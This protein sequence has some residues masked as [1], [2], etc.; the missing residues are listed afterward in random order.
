MIRDPYN[1][2]YAT[3]RTVAMQAA[4]VERVLLA[5]ENQAR[6]FKA[7]GWPEVV[8]AAHQAYS[9][10]LRKE[11]GQLMDRLLET[12]EGTELAAWIERTRGLGPAILFVVGMLPP[13]NEFANPSKVWKY[14]GLHVSDGRAPRRQAGVMAGFSARLRSYAIYRVAEPIVKVGGPYRAIYHERKARTMD[15][16]PDMLELSGGCE[17][18]DRARDRS[19][20]SREAKSLT[21]ERKTVGFDC[22]AVGGIHWTAGHRHADALRVLAKTI[23]LDAW[24]VAN[25]YEARVGGHCLLGTHDSDAPTIATG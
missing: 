5:L 24:R 2:Q 23:L 19:R 10:A 21:R 4:N 17:F 14:T 9:A 13:L 1:G 25:G 22:A 11:R 16:H 15:S 3:L 20:A 18:C 7:D 8:F 6:A 12:M